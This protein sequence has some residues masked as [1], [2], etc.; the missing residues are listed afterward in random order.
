[1]QITDK[2][3]IADKMQVID[4]WQIADKMQVKDKLQHM[5]KIQ[6]TGTRCRQVRELQTRHKMQAGQ[7]AANKA[8]EQ[9]TGHPGCR[10]LRSLKTRA[11]VLFVS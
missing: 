7:G 2:W 8:H 11:A 5:D 4:K 1:M 10:V 3:Q 6:T 9:K